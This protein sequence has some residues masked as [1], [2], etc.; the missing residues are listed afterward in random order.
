MKIYMFQMV[1]WEIKALEYDCMSLEMNLQDET[2]R[3]ILS[4]VF[5]SLISQLKHGIKADSV[6]HVY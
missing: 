3:I 4:S 2:C 1:A 5:M 6:L